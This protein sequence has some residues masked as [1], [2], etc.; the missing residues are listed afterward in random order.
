MTF[1]E[2]KTFMRDEYFNVCQ[3]KSVLEIG[4]HEGI[5]TKLITQYKPKY[6]ELVEPFER[7]AEYC[8]TLFGVDKV[9]KKDIF[10]VLN[11]KHFMDV[12]V[13][14]GVLYHLH[15]PLHLLELIVN[16]CDPKFIILDCSSDQKKISFEIE[17]DNRSGYRQL[18][19]NWR[20]AGFNLVA[21]FEII[22]QSMTNMGY[23]LIK[24][25]QFDSSIEFKSKQ[26]FWVGL[27]QRLEQ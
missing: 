16:N 7:A 21:P 22:N 1:D 3:N 23:T 9:I 8:E 24:K 13:C 18:M 26:N 25:H 17:D 19:N 4:P 10:F 20:S 5:H 15:S 11:D 14:C 27:W 2:Y 6:L 12:V